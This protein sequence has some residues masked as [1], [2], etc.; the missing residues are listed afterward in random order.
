MPAIDPDSNEEAE[1]GAD[2][3]R[4]EV[5]ECF[6]GLGMGSVGKLGMWERRRMGTHGKEEIADIVRDVYCYTHVREMESVAQPN[7]RE[8]D[9][10]MSNQ[11]FKVLPR[12]LQLQHEDDRLL[13]PIARL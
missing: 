9:Y 11:L 4:V 10:M 2:D 12:L 5:V 1:I 13:G 6:R 3:D 7:K 8:C